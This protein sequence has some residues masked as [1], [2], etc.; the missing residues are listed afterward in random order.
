MSDVSF[1]IIKFSAI[2]LFILFLGTAA[3]LFSVIPSL[4]TDGYEKIE[5]ESSIVVNEIIEFDTSTEAFLEESKTAMMPVVVPE[6]SGEIRKTFNNNFIQHE[7]ERV[8][9]N[10]QTLSVEAQ[11]LFEDKALQFYFLTVVSKDLNSAEARN[12]ADE[13]QNKIKDDYKVVLAVT[14]AGAFWFYGEGVSSLLSVEDKENLFLT[15]NDA[16][17]VN[18]YVPFKINLNVVYAIMACITVVA[19]LIVRCRYVLNKRVIDM[20]ILNTPLEVMTTEVD[21]LVKKYTQ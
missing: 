2:I 3:M 16:Y 17:T 11:R 8:T 12:E 7:N 9:F 13:M 21:H 4:V 5:E 15:F 6:F 14:D 19:L 20:E 18:P 10:E 1:D